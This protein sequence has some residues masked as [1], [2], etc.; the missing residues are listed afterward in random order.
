MLH[1]AVLYHSVVGENELRLRILVLWKI[2][3]KE[4]IAVLNM[5]NFT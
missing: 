3:L 5:S 2:T 4:V 1:I